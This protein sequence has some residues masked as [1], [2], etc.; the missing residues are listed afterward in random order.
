MITL[1]TDFGAEDSFV[2]EMKGVI[3]SIN[4]D[5]QLVD[6]W[7]GVRPQNIREAAFVFYT[8]YHYFPAGTIHLVAVDPG[9]GNIHKPIA[10]RA[11]GHVFIGPDNGVFSYILEAGKSSRSEASQP[12]Q[13]IHLVNRKYWRETISSTFRGRDIFAPVAAHLSRGVLFEELGDP[14]DNVITFS[15][16][17]PEIRSKG[18]IIGHVLYLDRFGN[19]IT[20]VKE[21]LLDPES[22]ALIEAGGRR[23]RGV[24][25][26]YSDVSPGEL[27]ALIGSSGYLEISIREGSAAALLNPRIGDEILITS[28]SN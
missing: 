11:E 18:T 23:M 14:L 24:R 25:R 28:I 27:V 6:L 9:A 22:D 17:E 7:H 5:V 4:A 16:S 21:N 1:T 26:H 8:A 13:I 19:I 10:I 2:G 20:D 12:P 15:M 3:L